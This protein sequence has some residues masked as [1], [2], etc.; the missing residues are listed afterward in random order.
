MAVIKIAHRIFRIFCARAVA[1]EHLVGEFAL[2][3]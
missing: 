2:L 1:H 3:V